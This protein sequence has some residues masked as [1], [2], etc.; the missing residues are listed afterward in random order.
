[1][2]SR[3]RR[4]AIRRLL[5]NIP[6]WRTVRANRTNK[7]RAGEV[8]TRS[9]RLFPRLPARERR[10][11]ED[12]PA[13]DIAGQG[14]ARTSWDIRSIRRRVLP[15]YERR[16]CRRMQPMSVSLLRRSL[17]ANKLTK[18]RLCCS[19]TDGHETFRTR[20]MMRMGYLAWCALMN[21]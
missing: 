14:Q 17:R 10:M 11:T 9:R 2:R 1:V 7:L 6:R 13:A 8:A 18:S 4:V 21:R 3:R 16:R 19:V 5:T 15:C 20:A 12:S